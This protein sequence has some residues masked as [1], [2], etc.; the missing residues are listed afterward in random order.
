MNIRKMLERYINNVLLDVLLIA[1]NDTLPHQETFEEWSKN[2]ISEYIEM[3]KGD[4][5]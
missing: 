1:Y 3:K 2:V 5:E 4:K